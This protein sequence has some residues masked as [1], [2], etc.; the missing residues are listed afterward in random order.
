VVDLLDLAA[1]VVAGFIS[2]VVWEAWEYPYRRLVADQF[3]K[4]ESALIQ[5]EI[6]T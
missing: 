6:P 2:N 4:F 5:V 1:G 3:A